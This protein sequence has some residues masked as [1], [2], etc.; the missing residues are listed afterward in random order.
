MAR[1]RHFPA[2]QF[3][4]FF[5]ANCNRPITGFGIDEEGTVRS[6]RTLLDF[7]I[8]IFGVNGRLG[9]QTIDPA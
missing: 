7:L 8:V 5:A 9:R 3:F 6:D 4:T 1:H 2:E